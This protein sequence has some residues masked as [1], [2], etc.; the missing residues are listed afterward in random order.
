VTFREEWNGIMITEKG[1][2]RKGWKDSSIRGTK[3]VEELLLVLY[4]SRITIG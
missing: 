1:M 3:T 4:Q 2:G